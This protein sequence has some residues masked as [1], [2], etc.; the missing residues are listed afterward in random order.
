VHEFPSLVARVASILAT[1]GDPVARADDPPELF[2]VD[3]QQ[4]AGMSALIAV[5]RLGRLKPAELAQADAPQHGRD[6]RQRHVQTP[7]NLGPGH[8]HT[9]QGSE[10]LDAILTGAMRHRP[11]RRRPINQPCLPLGPVAGQPLRAGAVAHS[12]GL[13]RPRD[14]PTLLDHTTTHHKPTLRAEH[15][16]RPYGSPSGLGGGVGTRA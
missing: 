7:G 6:R 5:G 13:G 12:G 3:V 4:L 14:R 2:D 15:G 10:H 11:R 1:S 9:P 16:V 8:P